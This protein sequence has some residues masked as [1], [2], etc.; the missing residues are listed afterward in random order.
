MTEAERLEMQA[1]MDKNCE[2][3][4]A[5]CEPVNDW[6][7]RKFPPSTRVLI[8]QGYAELLDGSVSVSYELL[9]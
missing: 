2:E 1:A 8:E 3:L 4:K 5:L 7:Q 9:D 6:L